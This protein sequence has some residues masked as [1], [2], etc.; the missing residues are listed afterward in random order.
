MYFP[1]EDAV[2]SSALSTD[3]ANILLSQAQWRENPLSTAYPEMLVAGSCP[4]VRSQEEHVLRITNH[5]EAC[6]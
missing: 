2:H 3:E 4:G 6:S 5:S 1:S